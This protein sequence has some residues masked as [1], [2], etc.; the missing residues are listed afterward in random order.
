M[1]SIIPIY[2]R[3]HLHTSATGPLDAV[4]KRAVRIVTDMILS[5]DMDQVNGEI[6]P[7]VLVL[8]FI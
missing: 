4:Q 5:N 6:L 7:V 3:K 2:G 1:R 8:R